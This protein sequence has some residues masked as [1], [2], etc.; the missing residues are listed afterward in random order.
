MRWSIAREIES[1]RQPSWFALVTAA[2]AAVLSF[3]SVGNALADE[4]SS[5]PPAKEKGHRRLSAR[6]CFEAIA[7]TRN[8]SAF[9]L[10]TE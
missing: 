4:K 1:S 2:G 6:P 8:S 3:A 9:P 10:C 5:P 7:P